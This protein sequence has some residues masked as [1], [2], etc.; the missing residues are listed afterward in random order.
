MDVLKVR[1]GEDVIIT[2]DT[3]SDWRVAEALARA[4]QVLGAKPL[5][6]WHSS[7]PSV[8][9]AAEPYIPS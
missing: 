9:R 5:V 6:T 3:G 4:T 1:E 7:A 2:T 8:D